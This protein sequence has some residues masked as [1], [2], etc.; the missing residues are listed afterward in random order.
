MIPSYNKW[1]WILGK[2]SFKKK[3]S[4]FIG[5]ITEKSLSNSTAINFIWLEE[6]RE[7]TH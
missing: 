1:K 7:K 5:N 2:T 6:Y 4:T 3:T